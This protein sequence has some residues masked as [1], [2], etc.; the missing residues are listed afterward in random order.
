MNMFFY[1]IIERISKEK[2]VW[3]NTRQE[4]VAYINGQPV[5]PRN[6]KNPHWN[7]AIGGEVTNMDKL[8][9]EFVK[10]VEA[11]AIE[12]GG[13]IEIN[14][15]KEDRENPLDREEV[16]D[17]VQV[18]GR[19]IINK[20]V[21]VETGRLLIERLTN[22]RINYTGCPLISDP[23]FSVYKMVIFWAF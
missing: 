9:E 17:V 1:Q 8:E 10:Q 23:T 4:P 18:E 12:E 7:L 14:R 13:N 22:L 20:L 16:M 3:F 11:R 5:T 6:K 2:L 15:D 21:S 19:F